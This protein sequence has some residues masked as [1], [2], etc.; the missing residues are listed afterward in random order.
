MP[1]PPAGSAGGGGVAG[2]GSTAS[3]CPNAAA[4]SRL[5]NRRLRW[6]PS[7][8]H[9]TRHRCLLGLKSMLTARLLGPQ[10]GHRS[11]ALVRG[12][13]TSDSPPPSEATARTR[14]PRHAGLFEVRRRGLEPPP[15][16]PGPGP[17][18]GMTG[19]RCVHLAL[20]RALCPA[21]WT[22]WTGW[23][24]WMLSTVLSRIPVTEIGERGRPIQSSCM[25]R[26]RFARELAFGAFTRRLPQ[27]VASVQDAAKG[28]LCRAPERMPTS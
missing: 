2:G 16:Y 17:Q 23:T 19:D 5:L 1:L 7:S 15:G 8:R 18:P 11:V 3:R 14:K 24:G 27:A 21:K 4:S 28:T 13:V 12:V 10:G 20:E 6:R 9:R 26:S 22:L 25:L